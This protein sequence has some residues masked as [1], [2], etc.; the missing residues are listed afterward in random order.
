MDKEFSIRRHNF[1]IAGKIIITSLLACMAVF[2]SLYIS[3][4]TFSNILETVDRISKPNNKIQLVNDLFRNVVNLDQLQRSQVLKPPA[5]DDKDPFLGEAGHVQLLLDSLRN[6]SM[7]NRTQVARIDSMKVLLRKRN[8][9]YL[10]YIKLRSTQLRNDTMAGQVKSLS[11]MIVKARPAMDSNLMTTS[12]TTKIIIDTLKEEEQKQSLWNRIFSKRKPQ[13]KQVQKEIKEELNVRVDTIAADNKGDSLARIGQAISRMEENR[14][15][16]RAQLIKQHVELNET[17]DI[18]VAQLMSI[19]NEIEQDEVDRTSRQNA[20]AKQQVNEGL[21]NISTVLVIFISGTAILVFLIFIDIARSN[22]NRRQLLVARDEAEE[23]GRV[24]QRFLAN[25]SHELRTPLQSIIGISEQ[26]RSDPKPQARDLENIHQSSLHLLQIVNEVLD[27]SRI[28]SGKYMLDSKPFNMYGLLCEV[29][30][31]VQVQL[32]IKQLAFRLDVQVPE[33]TYYSGDPFRLKQVMLNLLGNAAK[34]TDKGA[35]SLKVTAA[36]MPDGRVLFTFVVKDTGIGIPAADLA[37]IFNEFEQGGNTHRKAGTG[38][39]LSIVKAM[40]DIQKGSITAASEPGKGTTFTMAI[41]YARAQ[42]P[43]PQARHSAAVV[44]YAQQ[45]WVVDD[46][47]FILQLC[48][49]ILTKHHIVHT[50]FSSAQAALA[51]PL[52]PDIGIVFLDIR[53]GDMSGITLCRMLRERNT[54][55]APRYLALTAQ[56]LPEERQSILQKG[57]DGLVMKPFLE[58]DLLDAIAGNMPVAERVAVPLPDLSPVYKMAGGDEQLVAEVLRSFLA[59]TKKDLVVVSD[60]LRG[61]DSEELAGALHKLAGRC[62][63]VGAVA[64]S[65]RLRS[66][67]IALFKDSNAAMLA[68]VVTALYADVD[69][70]C[71]TIVQLLSAHVIPT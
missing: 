32:T 67:E 7:G 47:V 17:G 30:E 40:V 21:T 35:V 11:E 66:A 68:P 10:Q 24:K 62:G 46:D 59:E 9:L 19:L 49:T 12:S 44:S 8:A 39:G 31:M 28:I 6:V 23:A 37:V 18:L 38:L 58:Q 57:F 51:A 45:V 60:S 20:A 26:V 42:P 53:I 63:Q 41:P 43:L 1:S 61:N 29:K 16:R 69:A 50:C 27:Y 14:M 15:T 70:L 4:V 5:D 71:A 52:P 54:A 55:V 2:L 25:M 13:L 34:F 65:A 56:A 3:R 33:D 22:R 36:D 64:L 48:D